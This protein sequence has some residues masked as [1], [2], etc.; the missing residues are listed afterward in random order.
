MKLYKEVINGIHI[1]SNEQEAGLVLKSYLV[2]ATEEEVEKAKSD[3]IKNKK[4]AHHF[5]Y[6][7]PCW[8]YDERICGICKRHIAFI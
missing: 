1:T 5:T 2:E 4:C 7:K 8:I 6:D 3:F